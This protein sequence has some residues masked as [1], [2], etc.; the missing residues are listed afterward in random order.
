M[1]DLGMCIPEIMIKQRLYAC[2]YSSEWNQV[3][4]CTRPKPKYILRSDVRCWLNFILLV[5]E[6][7]PLKKYEFVNWDDDIPNWM[8]KSSR[9]VPVTTNQLYLHHANFASKATKMYL[10]STIA[11]TMHIHELYTEVCSW[12]YQ[13]QALGLW[14]ETLAE[15]VMGCVYIYIICDM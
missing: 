8:G 5:V 7:T 11:M 2:V 13:P 10:A 15:Y 1:S 12:G 4:L 6:P 3:R 9:H 14:L